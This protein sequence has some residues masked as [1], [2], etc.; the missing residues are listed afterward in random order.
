VLPVASDLDLW[1]DFSFGGDMAIIGL[2]TGLG[3]LEEVFPF[4]GLKKIL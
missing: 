2:L 1:W 3:M 4:G